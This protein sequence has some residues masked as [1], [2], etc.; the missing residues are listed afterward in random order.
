MTAPA[1]FGGPD[2]HTVG[3]ETLTFHAGRL[4]S[5][6][7]RLVTM[8]LTQHADTETFRR[9][10]TEKFGAPTGSSRRS[11]PGEF[12]GDIEETNWIRSDTRI[13]LIASPRNGPIT[14]EYSDR[15]FEPKRSTAQ[16]IRRGP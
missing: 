14:L 15:S 12:P 8:D 1:T 11:S 2:T 7:V 5:V 4:A 9:A 3:N 6:A 13:A 10:L 16:P